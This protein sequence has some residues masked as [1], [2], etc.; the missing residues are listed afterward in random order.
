[1]KLFVG[2][3]NPGSKYQNNRHNVGFILLDRLAQDYGF[4]SWKAKAG[5]QV[6]SGRIGTVKIIAAKPQSF[7]NKSGLPVAELARFYKIEPSDIYVFHDEIDL[8]EGRLRVKQGGGHGGHNGL[9]DIDRH[10][11]K[12]YWRVRI[13]VGR[14]LTKEDV[15]K[16]VLND[17]SRHDKDSWL[18]AMLDAL[19]SEAEY[20]SDGDT[21]SY[22][23]RVA[24][25][26]P[27]PQGDDNKD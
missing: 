21:A 20:L 18:M 12:D 8:G 17:F 26:A 9:R 2:L 6:A 5:A 25:R 13:G 16:W 7:M 4:E 23:S 15:H 1:M 3:G 10:M 19:S 27:A 14:P 24:W 11:G 22:M